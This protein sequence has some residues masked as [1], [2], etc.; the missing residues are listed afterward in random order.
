MHSAVKRNSNRSIIYV[1][2]I[3][4]FVSAQNL[5]AIPPTKSVLEF[6]GIIEE[7][8]EATALKV[9]PFS[10][11]NNSGGGKENENNLLEPSSSSE[12]RNPWSKEDIL[13]LIQLY[14]KHDKLFKSS[15]LKNDKVWGYI[16][17][18]MKSHTSE[19]CKNKWKYLKAKYMEKKDNMGIKS[20]GSKFI[21]FEFFKE[22]DD[23]FGKEPNV[24][25]VS[26]ASSSKGIDNIKNLSKP[27]VSDI[28]SENVQSAKKRKRSVLE[29]KLDIY[30]NNQ[31]EKDKLGQTRHKEVLERQDKAINIL[32]R[33]AN[34]FERFVD[35]NTREK[36]TEKNT[37]DKRVVNNASKVCKENTN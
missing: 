18:E 27:P 25:P 12:C 23:I 6:F 16:S 7:A 1:V 17:Q 32:E 29:K 26:V 30:E 21:K 14:K 19:Q 5:I 36:S 31:V 37:S 28:L 20:T 10:N 22:F 3:E 34:A 24:V 33:M 15:S 13:T 4:Y 9:L 2:I 35:N 8:G 11:D